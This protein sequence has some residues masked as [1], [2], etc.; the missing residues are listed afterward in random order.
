MALCAVLLTGATPAAAAD[1]FEAANRRIHDFNRVVQQ[2]LLSPAAAFYNAQVPADLRRRIGNAFANLGEPVTAASGL[3]VGDVG[4]AANALARFGINVTLGLGGMEDAAAPRGYPRRPFGPADAACAWG[5]P[6]GPY[7]VLPLAGP[8]TLRDAAAMLATSVALVQALG[9]EAVGAWQAGDAF[10]G[11][12]AIH[13][14]LDEFDAISLDG[15][16]AQRSAHLQRRALA[17]RI[18]RDAALPG[19]GGVAAAR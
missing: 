17:C 2:Q 19:E 16:A 1:P 12:A 14:D 11:Y 3:A 13:R 4:L 5:V 9:S 7:L 18:D 10:V 6:R 8:S 15:Y